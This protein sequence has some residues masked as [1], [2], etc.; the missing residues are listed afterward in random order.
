MFGKSER[1]RGSYRESREV[2][3]RKAGGEPRSCLVLEYKKGTYVAKRRKKERVQP[4]V[5][6]FMRG[7]EMCTLFLKHKCDYITALL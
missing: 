1:E 2:E 4:R 3:V 7:S 5:S 6:R